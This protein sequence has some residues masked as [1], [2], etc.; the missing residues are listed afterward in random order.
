MGLCAGSLAA[1]ILFGG[2]ALASGGLPAKQ[3]RALEAALLSDAALDERIDLALAALAVPAPR[4]RRA[5]ARA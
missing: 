4:K 3:A 2:A 5:G 1:P